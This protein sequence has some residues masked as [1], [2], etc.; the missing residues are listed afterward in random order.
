MKTKKIFFTLFIILIIIINT[1]CYAID[2]NAIN[3][4]TDGISIYSESV[5]LI[6][7]NTGTTLYEKNSNQKMYP[8]ST[9]KILTAILSIEN[10]NLDDKTTVQY[11]AISGIPSGYS[12]A[13]LTEGE[14]ISV[15]ELLE[16][17]L[18]HSA[19]EAGNVLAE[20]ISGSIDEFVNL[21]NQ[22]AAELGCT[23]THFVNTNGIHNENHYTTAYDLALIARYCMKNDTFRQIVSMKSCTIPATNKS[24]QREYKNTN[25]LIDTSSEY[26]IED[27]IGVKTG[28]TSQAQNCLVSAFN[29]NG[30]EVIAVVLG[31]P[32]LE[33]GESARNIDSTTLYNYAYSNY[34]IKNIANK[35]DII[36]NIDVKNGN[37]DTKNL[38]LIL[39][40]NIPALVS[41]N[42]ENIT[43]TIKLNDSIVA[44]I[45]ANSVIGT[46]TYTSQGVEYTENLLASHDVVERDYKFI[47]IGI[48]VILILILFMILIKILNKNKKHIRRH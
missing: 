17:F 46:I 32:K 42:N 18:I 13:Y 23:N 45:S 35:N 21:M 41:T 40:D 27:C 15:R 7:S 4:D 5:I 11:D 19:N 36:Y 37:R 16:V 22:K 6:D 43:Y 26:Y 25:N 12:S 10:G 29:K 31:A 44:P 9:T 33:S 47:F 20:Y 38:D 34:T 3:A 48:S 28:F 2:V 30:F 1:Y 14:I 8:A 24:D 39:E